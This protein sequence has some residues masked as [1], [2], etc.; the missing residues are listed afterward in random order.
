MS[1]VA[2][3]VKD[4]IAKQFIDNR[5][6][7]DLD[8]GTRLIE[9]DIIDSLGIFALVSFLMERF[10]IN[11]EPEEVDLENFHTVDAIARLVEG[12]LDIREL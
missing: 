2:R 11:I 5:Y 8:S 1:E 10:G 9:E 7:K 4:H 12:K 3:I 6:A